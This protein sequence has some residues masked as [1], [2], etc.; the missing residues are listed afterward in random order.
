MNLLPED[1][2]PH[3]QALIGTMVRPGDV[4]YDIGAHT[5]MM[6]KV[7]LDHGAALVVA[8]EPQH[9]LAQGLKDRFTN[10]PVRVV[11]GAVWDTYGWGEITFPHDTEAGQAEVY[12]RDG[13]TVPLIP[14]DILTLFF[15]YPNVMKVDIQ[16]SE[17]RMLKGASRSLSQCRAIIVELYDPLLIKH[18]SSQAECEKLLLSYGFSFVGSYS[19]DYLWVKV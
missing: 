7:A 12:G 10:A 19:N 5:G 3:I 17:G 1:H 13:G 11:D 4:F 2:D 15:G 18:E 8:I 9:D 6:T 14:L 16:G